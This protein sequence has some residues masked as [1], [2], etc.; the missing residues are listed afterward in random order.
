VLLLP[1]RLHVCDTSEDVLKRLKG[2]FVIL[3]CLLGPPS[4]AS[5]GPIDLHLLTPQFLIPLAGQTGSLTIYSNGTTQTSGFNALG[6]QTFTLGANS[7]STGNL[8]LNLV[9]SGAPLGQPLG[10]IAAATLSMSLFDFDFVTDQITQRVTLTEAA[11]LNK[12]N[13]QWL[14]LIDRID[15]STHLA[16]GTPTDDRWVHLSPIS[17]LPGPLSS[18]D[19]VDPLML[20]FKLTATARNTGSS[21]VTLLN[22]PEALVSNVT[23]SL[24]PV[25]QVPEPSA[26]LLAGIGALALRFRKRSVSKG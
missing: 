9:F 3:V 26:L 17:L 18:S 20:S 23:L 15:L 11:V 24:T 13:G 22:T 12:V 1:G 19:F 21:S 16:P 14:P 4:A 2:W 6:S 10:D 25:S 5:A 8:T 7:T